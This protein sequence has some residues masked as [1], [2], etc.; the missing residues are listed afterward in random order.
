MSRRHLLP[1]AVRAVLGRSATKFEA[2]LRR[3]L[4][5]GMARKLE[6]LGCGCTDERACPGGC[7]WSEPG[8]CTRCAPLPASALI[9]NARAERIV[10]QRKRQYLRAGFRSF[11][12]MSLAVLAWLR[13]AGMVESHRDRLKEGLRLRPFTTIRLG[14]NCASLKLDYRPPKGCHGMR[15]T[16]SYLLRWHAGPR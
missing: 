12:V 13:D 8:I 15:V 5:D 4:L 3:K 9:R 14:K 1:R 2:G 6:C 10:D 11:P 7:A 16:Y